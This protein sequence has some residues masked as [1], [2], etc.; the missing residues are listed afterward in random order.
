MLLNTFYQASI[1][2]TSKLDK[3]ITKKENYRL[4]IPID[5]GAK[6]SVN[7]GASASTSILPV[8]IQG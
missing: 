5:T 7:I 1:T 3:D 8:N 2:P 6:C 4:I